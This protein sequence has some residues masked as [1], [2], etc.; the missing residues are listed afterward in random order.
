MSSATRNLR[1]FCS[2]E[3]RNLHT[4]ETFRRPFVFISF[5][6]DTGSHRTRAA[7]EPPKKPRAV[8]DAFT[9]VKYRVTIK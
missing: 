5:R 3:E 2:E 6:Y 8:V 9:N 4:R 1:S 7:D